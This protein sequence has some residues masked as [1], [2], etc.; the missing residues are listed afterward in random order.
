LSGIHD[1]NPGVAKHG[2][3]VYVT[4]VLDTIHGRTDDEALWTAMSSWATFQPR[5]NMPRSGPSHLYYPNESSHVFEKYWD[6]LP[7]LCDHP[8]FTKETPYCQEQMTRFSA[9]LSTMNLEEFERAQRP[10]PRTPT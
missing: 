2:W 6:F 5:H 10:K 4:Q 3:A 7:N 8:D 1:L 9:A